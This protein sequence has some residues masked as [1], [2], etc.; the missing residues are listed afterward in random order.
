M[1]PTIF[2]YVARSLGKTIRKHA[3]KMPFLCRGL[4]GQ[5]IKRR[6]PSKHRFL[7][8]NVRRERSTNSFK[9]DSLLRSLGSRKRKF[10][11]NCT[12][13][14]YRVPEQGELK[15]FIGKRLSSKAKR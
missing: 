4:L 11:E 15:T 7:Q 6:Q 13:M 10:F 9:S 8:K 1:A 5:I 12:E 2:L 3:F 14:H